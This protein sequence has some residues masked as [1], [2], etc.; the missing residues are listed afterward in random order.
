MGQLQDQMQ[1]DLELRGYSQKTKEAYIRHMKNFCQHYGKSPDKLGIKEVHEYLHLLVTKKL[2]SSYINGVYSAMKFF[3][4]KTLEKDIPFEKIPRTKGT[5]KLPVVLD[6]A[7]VNKI[8]DA[9]NN[10]KHK[11][12]LITTYSA[13]LR[14]SETANLKV[15]DIDSKRMQIRVEQGKGRKDRYT[16]L[17]QKNLEILR[18]YW[19]YYRPV[20]WLFPGQIVDKPIT[21]RTIQRIFAKAKERAGIKKP[22]SVHT[23]R[24]SFAT[25][26]LEAG[27]DIYH[28]Q[29]LMGH[30]SP[31]TT[32]IYIHIRRQ[33]LLKIVSPLDMDDQSW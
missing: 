26:L 10:L 24:H 27:T 16:I 28:I 12:F 11:A 32:S 30:T 19:K 29:H 2:S 18:E 22:A 14:V 15:T 25:H 5:K 1:K 4:E 6:L 20:T 33:D 9:T 7:E 13:G 3:Y 21:A 31:K 17:S 23:L 8:L